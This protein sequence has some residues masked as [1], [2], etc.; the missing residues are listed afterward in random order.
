VFCFDEKAKQNTFALRVSTFPG[1]Q[2]AALQV[3]YGAAG[4]LDCQL[5]LRFAALMERASLGELERDA[6]NAIPARAITAPAYA[7]RRALELTVSGRREF[8]ERWGIPADE[9]LHWKSK[10]IRASVQRCATEFEAIVPMELEG[11]VL[12]AVWDFV[13]GRY[14]A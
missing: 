14:G 9:H 6:E 13:K 2:L 4:D 12:P 10:T 7:A 11:P 1:L 8:M 3:R 5:R